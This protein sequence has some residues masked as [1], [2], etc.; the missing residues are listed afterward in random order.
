MS[1]GIVDGDDEP[2][3]LLDG[4]TEGYEEPE[5]SLA[6]TKMTRARRWRSFIAM[7]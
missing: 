3:G 1:L 5:G 7:P 4:A 2:D 6:L